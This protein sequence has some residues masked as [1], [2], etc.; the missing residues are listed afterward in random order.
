ME[1]FLPFL[2]FLV[3]DTNLVNA[4]VTLSVIFLDTELYLSLTPA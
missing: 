1:N 4:L 2:T 3:G